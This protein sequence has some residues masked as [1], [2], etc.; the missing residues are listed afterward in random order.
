MPNARSSLRASLGVVIRLR[1]LEH[2]W[3]IEDLAELAQ[4]HPT[5]ISELERG[6]KTA[7]LASI[8]AVAAAL[9]LR[10]SELVRQAEDVES[11][12]ESGSHR[13]PL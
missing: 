4:L 5:Y 12:C 9:V 10:P 6:R 2:N 3:T 1:R 13:I 7:S 11:T 8:E